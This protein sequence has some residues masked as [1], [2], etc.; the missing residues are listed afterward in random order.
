MGLEN[1]LIAGFQADGHQVG[2]GVDVVRPCGEDLF[3]Q[4]PGIVKLPKK[5]FRD[6]LAKRRLL[7]ARLLAQ[8]YNFV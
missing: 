6:R 1:R 5:L 2:Q 4:S 7:V 8:S 3:V